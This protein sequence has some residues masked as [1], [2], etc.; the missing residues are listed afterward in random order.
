MI[1]ILN[2]YKKTMKQPSQKTKN[3]TKKTKRLVNPALPPLNI[4][5]PVV[6]NNGIFFVLILAFCVVAQQLQ[7]HLPQDNPPQV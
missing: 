5:E 2:L 7:L 4:L 1:F 6:F 3:L